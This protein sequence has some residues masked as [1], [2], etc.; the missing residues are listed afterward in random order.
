MTSK[1][2]PSAEA[3]LENLANMKLEAE[4]LRDMFARHR[5]DL[6][7]EA[8]YAVTEQGVSVLRAATTAGIDRRTLNVWLQVHNAEVKARKK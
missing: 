2:E 1:Y 7:A 8:I 3:A 6:R 4:R 5:E